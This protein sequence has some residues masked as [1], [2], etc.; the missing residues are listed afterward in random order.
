MGVKYHED[1]NDELVARC[2][3]LLQRFNT[4]VL[5]LRGT[6]AWTHRTSLPQAGPRRTPLSA[7]P[8]RYNMVGALGK[9]NGVISGAATSPPR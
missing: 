3:R 5:C 2:G 1:A 7:S 9:S 4:C 8:T 6:A